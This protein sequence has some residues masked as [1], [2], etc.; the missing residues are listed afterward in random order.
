MSAGRHCASARSARSRAP[1]QRGH[2]PRLSQYVV[3]KR[4]VDPNS[5]LQR[6][7][8]SSSGGGVCDADP[9]YVNLMSSQCS[10][11]IIHRRFHDIWQRSLDIWQ[12]FGMPRWKFSSLGGGNGDA[13]RAPEEKSTTSGVGD[14]GGKPARRNIWTDTKLIKLTTGY[15]SAT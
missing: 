11:C 1:R 4:G 10:V 5:F 14:A 15:G 6:G 8:E 7:K 12:R 13:D 3:G 2:D 9:P